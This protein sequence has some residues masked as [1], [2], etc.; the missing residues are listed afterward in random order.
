MFSCFHD[1]KYEYSSSLILLIDILLQFC[2]MKV[3]S[4]IYEPQEQHAH[5]RNA[6]GNILNQIIY[7]IPKKTLCQLLIMQVN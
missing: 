6:A 4:F 3:F 7:F 2:M 5:W 1:E